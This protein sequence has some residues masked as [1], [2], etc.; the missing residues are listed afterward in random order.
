MPLEAQRWDE[1][2][3]PLFSQHMVVRGQDIVAHVQT[4][5]FRFRGYA[6]DNINKAKQIDRVQTGHHRLSSALSLSRRGNRLD[7]YVQLVT[8]ALQDITCDV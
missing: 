4:S 3:G 6:Q 8:L 5:P 2:K 7:Y 1:H